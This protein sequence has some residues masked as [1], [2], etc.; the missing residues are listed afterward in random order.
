MNVIKLFAIEYKRSMLYLLFLNRGSHPLNVADF[1]RAVA[2]LS[3]RLEAHRSSFIAFLPESADFVMSPN[4]PLSDSDGPAPYSEDTREDGT[5]TRE[6]G[7][8][9]LRTRETLRRSPA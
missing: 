7:R 5:R 4:N 3:L 6:R 1:A 8:N 2:W 9:Y